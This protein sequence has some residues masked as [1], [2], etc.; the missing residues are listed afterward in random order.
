MIMGDADDSYDFLEIPRFVASCAKATISFR[1]AGCLPAA[2]TLCPE[3][4]P[5]CIAGGA[6]RCFRVWSRRWFGA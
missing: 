4:C 2:A 3:R 6:I 1:A 5:F